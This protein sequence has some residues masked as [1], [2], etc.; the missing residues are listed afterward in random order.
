MTTQTAIPSTEL[1]PK[2][3]LLPGVTRLLLARTNPV[4]RSTDP[5]NLAPEMLTL[6][7]T[8]ITVVLR[9]ILDDKGYRHGGIND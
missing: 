9:E 6:R 4:I 2:P 5:D 8:K 1:L 7:A 3:L